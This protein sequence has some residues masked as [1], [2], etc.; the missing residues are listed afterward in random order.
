LSEGVSGFIGLIDVTFIRAE[1][2]AVAAETRVQ[3]VASAKAEIVQISA[4]EP[5][6]AAAA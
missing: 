4:L 1:G 3:A 6:T 2:V 5:V